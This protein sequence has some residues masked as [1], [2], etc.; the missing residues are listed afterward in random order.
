MSRWIDL[1]VCHNM[2][3]AHRLLTLP[4]KCQN[5]HGHGMMVT[6]VLNAQVDV[7][8]YALYSDGT[9]IEFGDVKKQFRE[10]IDGQFDHKLHLN[11]ID[12]WAQKLGIEHN[13]QGRVLTKAKLPGLVAWPADPSTENFAMWI[14]DECRKMFGTV[15]STVH[16]RET[17][18]NGARYRG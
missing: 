17:G 1:E 8:G 6:L 3:V 12:P 11:E 18:S 16:V 9:P 7:N 14:F 5:I 13:V 4:G 15:V 10:F 2:E